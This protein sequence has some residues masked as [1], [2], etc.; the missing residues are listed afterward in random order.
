MCVANGTQQLAVFNFAYI[1]FQGTF[2]INHDLTEN[3]VLSK[4]TDTMVKLRGY[5]YKRSNSLETTHGNI[6]Y[7]EC[8]K[9]QN[10]ISR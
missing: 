1:L 2:K 10:H 4:E 5:Q 9:Q 3:V 8:V 6:I 7:L